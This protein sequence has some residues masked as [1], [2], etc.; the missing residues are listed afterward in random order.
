MKALI[1]AF[2]L[3]TLIAGPTF[4]Q[5]AY[6]DEQGAAHNV[7]PSSSAFGDNGY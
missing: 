2:A 6:S 3:L 4:A 1:T 7:S 5:S